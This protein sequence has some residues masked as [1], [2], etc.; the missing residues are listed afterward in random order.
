MLSKTCEYN[1]NWFKPEWTG[2]VVQLNSFLK[3]PDKSYLAKHTYVKTYMQ[4]NIERRSN[5]HWGYTMNT[6]ILTKY[7]FIVSKQFTKIIAA[8]Q[9]FKLFTYFTVTYYFVRNLCD[10]LNHFCT[11]QNLLQELNVFSLNTYNF[12]KSKSLSTSIINHT[13]TLFYAA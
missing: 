5:D 2:W 6:Y 3:P 8:K 9:Y 10:D 13:P 11:K 1:P 12:I 7:S 4:E